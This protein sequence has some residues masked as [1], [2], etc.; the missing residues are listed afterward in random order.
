MF[1]PNILS[2]DKYA[3]LKLISTDV[4]SV[5]DI[6]C[7][8]GRMAFEIS[9]K[10]ANA[11]VVGVDGDLEYIELAKKMYKSDNLTFI[12]AK[13]DEKLKFGENSFDL[14]IFIDVIEHLLN[15]AFVL[16]EIYSLLKPGGILIVSTDNVFYIRNFFKYILQSY[17]IL[18]VKA[19]IWH[20]LDRFY[21][22]N[23]HLY[24][25]QMDTLYTL[26]KV[27]GFELISNHFSSNQPLSYKLS[28]KIRTVLFKLFPLVSNKIIIKAYKAK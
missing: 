20:N 15:P 12:H 21:A 3:V 2:C 25:W 4:K 9:K 17:G 6:G 26:L 7:G 24:T 23:Q 11:K 22:W 27:S 16:K 14:V 5:L 8:G 13:I 10:M 19:H 18:K 1:K 28:C